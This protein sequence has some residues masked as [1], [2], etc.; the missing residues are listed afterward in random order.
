MFRE[1]G[2]SLEAHG[3]TV[4]RI[5]LSGGDTRDWPDPTVAFKG[6]FSEWPVFID[7]FLRQYAITDILLF[8]DC[9]P[10]HVTARGMAEMRGIRT[11]VLEEG[12]LRPHWMTLEREGVNARSLL[13]R[14]KAWF[15]KEALRLPA[16]DDLPPVTAS[17][18]RRARDSYWHYHR[19]VTGR[20]WFPHY[21]SHRSGSI[22]MEGLGWLWKFARQ[23][24]NERRAAEVLA[25]LAGKPLF[26]LPLQLSGDYQIRA[27]SSFPNMKSAARY[28]IESFATHAPEDA[29]LLLKTHPMDISF[30]D[31]G[32]FVRRE[33]RRLHL[34]GRLHYADGGDLD[35]II[36]GAKGLVCVNSTSATLALARNVPVCTIGEAIYDLEGLT[37]QGH[38]DSFWTTPSASE[39]G[40]YEAFRRVLVDRCLVRGGLASESAVTT[41]VENMTARLLNEEG[42]VAPAV[43]EADVTRLK[44]P[45]TSR[46]ADEPVD[47]RPA[48]SSGR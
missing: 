15:R 27:H 32:R 17:F 33:A 38:L 39:P 2:R 36:E 48:T 1:L 47:A 26:V 18:R 28:V 13:S 29:H 43:Q 8:G 19:V 6:H 31:W 24:G 9:R 30:F 10:H 44:A 45:R 7:R 37:H 20:L 3:A 14:D 25:S 34:E 21:R 46:Q 16:E 23:K 22:I 40:L 35:A 5:N 41:L 42:Q 4:F 12:Y 11:H